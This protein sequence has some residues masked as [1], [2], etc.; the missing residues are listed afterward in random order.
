[1][2]SPNLQGIP[3][4]RKSIF[5]LE[6]EYLTLMSDIMDLDGEITDDIIERL[7]INREELDEKLSKYRYMIKIY[8]KNITIE[9]EYIAEHTAKKKRIENA[10]GRLKLALKTAIDVFGEAPVDKKGVA[11]SK[12]IEYSEGKLMF[13]KTNNVVITAENLIPSEYIKDI[14]EIKDSDIENLVFFIKSAKDKDEAIAFIRNHITSRTVSKSEI[15]PVL[16]QGVSITGAKLD[17]ESG[18]IRFY[19]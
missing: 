1:M 3:T 13:I 5:D 16:K 8:E 15:A 11:K 12:Q 10:I 18:Y 9:D 19:V 14:I 6:D 4:K 17:T 2:N 7:N